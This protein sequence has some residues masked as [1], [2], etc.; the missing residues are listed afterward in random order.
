MQRSPYSGYDAWIKSQLEYSYQECGK[1]G[2]TSIPPP[3]IDPPT[4][5]NFCVS[6]RTITTEEG[7]TCDS[8]ASAY[9]LSSASLYASNPAGIMDCSRIRAGTKICL[10]PSCGVT[11]A[12]QTGDTCLS[13]E[14][15]VSEATG[16]YM[17]GS[18]RK[19]NRWV[20]SAC[21]NLH[22]A[23]ASLGHILCMVPPNGYHHGNS[24][25]DHTTPKPN[26]GYANR[27]TPPPANAIIAEGTTRNCGI[28]YVATEEDACN[29]IVFQHSTTID[30]FMAVNPSLGTSIPD[31][32]E[33]V[34]PGLTYC[35]KP[36]VA[37]NSTG[38]MQFQA[39]VSN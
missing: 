21:G 13:I 38:V 17:I 14:R 18:I 32:A 36:F 29:S 12:L 9:G 20:D 30:I 15:N 7:D 23:S 37:W 16:Q 35:A 5:D 34:V 4:E 26:L 19:Y 1:T 27:I 11:Y 22:I 28:W 33:N 24:S 10:P 31:C 8:I 3:P 6:S 39:D 2:D 25:G